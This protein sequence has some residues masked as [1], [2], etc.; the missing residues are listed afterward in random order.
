MVSWRNIGHR[1][2][3]FVWQQHG[4]DVTTTNRR[5]ALSG[6]AGSLLFLCEPAMRTDDR[7]TDERLHGPSC[8][9]L[10]S[11]SSPYHPLHQNAANQPP[12]PDPPNPSIDRCDGR[13]SG[14]NWPAPGGFIHLPRPI[15]SQ[16]IN[17]IC[18]TLVPY[19]HCTRRIDRASEQASRP[20]QR[21]R[22]KAQRSHQTEC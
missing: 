2:V 9:L 10:S 7:R 4:H 5:T 12:P 3:G 15:S 1:L 8:V 18:V 17:I 19:T 14:G 13:K 22:H 20:K 6:S 21:G 16:I 11:S